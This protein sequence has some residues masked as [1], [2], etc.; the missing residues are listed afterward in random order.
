M[1][2]ITLVLLQALRLVFC[3]TVSDPNDNK[4]NTPF[5]LQDPSDDQCLGP[6]GFVQCDEKAL[7]ILTTRKGRKTYSLVS[8][9]NPDDNGL[10]L[11]N[12]RGYFGFSDKVGMGSCKSKGSQSWDF[13]FVDDKHVKVSTNDKTLV[14]GKYYKSSLSLEPS[15]REHFLF[16]YYPTAVHDVGFY[17]KAGDGKCF[18][19]E[20]FRE[21][22]VN[23]YGVLWAIGIKYSWGKAYRYIYNHKEKDTCLLVHG[24]KVS[25]GKCSDSKA[26]GWSLRDGRLSYLNDKKCLVRKL[27]NLGVM[28]KCG[29][30][31]E[32]MSLETPVTYT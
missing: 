19:G 21:C 14:R 23:R 17:L 30:T 9:L 31:F 25:K 6:N 20:K 3:K 2:L 13:L 28:E 12:K 7:W 26:L 32:Y 11:E 29:N 24:Y 18:D 10:C 8:L 27:D 16:K 15:T 22:G 4:G 5:F 1:F